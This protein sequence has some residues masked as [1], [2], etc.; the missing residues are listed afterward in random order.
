[1]AIDLQI[2]NKDKEI[3]HKSNVWWNEAHYWLTYTMGRISE[4]TYIEI[5][6]YTTEGMPVDNGK[7]K[8]FDD[9]HGFLRRVLEK[10]EEGKYKGVY[11]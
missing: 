6:V 7:F 3:R 9:A 5:Q 2:Y 4:F 8:D 11:L 1:M 10:V